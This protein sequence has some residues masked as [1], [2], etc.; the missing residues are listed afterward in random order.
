MPG[1]VSMGDFYDVG[2]VATLS[3]AV[4]A[5]NR[6]PLNVGALICLFQLA[7]GLVNARGNLL[8]RVKREATRGRL[9]P[10]S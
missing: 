1:H 6:P 5:R 7:A 3:G 4:R 8:K 10:E 2:K 9:M